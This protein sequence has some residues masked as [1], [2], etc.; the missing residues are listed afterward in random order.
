MPRR[1]RANTGVSIQFALPDGS[2]VDIKAG[3]VKEAH[4]LLDGALE[5]RKV[6]NKVPRRLKP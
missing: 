5:A 4:T 1:K 2:K 6:A 3:N